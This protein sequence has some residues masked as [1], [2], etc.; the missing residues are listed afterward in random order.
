[1]EQEEEEEEEQEQ[2]EE[3]EEKAEEEKEEG[4]EEKGEGRRA[5]EK[6]LVMVEG[7]REVSRQMIGSVSSVRKTM[8][9]IIH[10]NELHY[11]KSM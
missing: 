5:G 2:E 8:H 10:N 7:R 3:E 9:I 4:K 1:M 11:S 6:R